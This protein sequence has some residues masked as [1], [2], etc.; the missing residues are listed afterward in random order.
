MLSNGDRPDRN[1][2]LFHR[3]ARFERPLSLIAMQLADASLHTTNSTLPFL[4]DERRSVHVNVMLASNRNGGWRHSHVDVTAGTITR[5]TVD[6]RT[7]T[8]A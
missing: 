4:V 7:I 6:I 3:Q 2:A 1:I 8:T 5:H